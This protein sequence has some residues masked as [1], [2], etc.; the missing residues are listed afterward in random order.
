[1]TQARL[2]GGTGSEQITSATQFPAALT[3]DT[4]PSLTN[5]CADLVREKHIEVP[6]NT[7][8][9]VSFTAEQNGRIAGLRV[10]NTTVAT[11]ATVGGRIT[12]VNQSSS[13]AEIIDYG[14]G[15]GTNS[16]AAD[17]Q[18]VTIAADDSLEVKNPKTIAAANRFNKGDTLTFTFTPDGTTWLGGID[19]LFE[20]GSDGR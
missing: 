13:D 8:H 18:T 3:V 4:I 7:T 15:G 6:A 20:Y 10:S 19:L 16:D 17:T 12:V 1:M 2:P 14:I 11:S 5:R 9:V